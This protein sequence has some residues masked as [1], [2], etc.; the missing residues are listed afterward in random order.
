[1]SEESQKQ[2]R[3]TLKNAVDRCQQEKMKI[4]EV[5]MAINSVMREWA[6]SENLEITIN[7]RGK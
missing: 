2:A 5:A 1:M 4:W 6:E 7:V 3:E